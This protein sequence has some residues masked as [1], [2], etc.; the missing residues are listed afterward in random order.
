[1]DIGSITV[2]VTIATVALG[3]IVDETTPEVVAMLQ[4]RADNICVFS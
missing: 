1:M 2:G 3:L 4:R